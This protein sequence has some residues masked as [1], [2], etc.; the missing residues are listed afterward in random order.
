METEISSNGGAP[1]IRGELAGELT[2]ALQ[3]LA[4]QLHTAGD[5]CD[6][7]EPMELLQVERSKE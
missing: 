2:Q 6:P 7:L 1:K 5:A 4:R 3:R